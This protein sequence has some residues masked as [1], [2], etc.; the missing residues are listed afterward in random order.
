MKRISI[1]AGFT[2]V[3][4][5][6]V[7]TII[8]VLA[9]IILTSLNDARKEGID[10]KIMV[11]MGGIAKRAAIDNNEVFTYDVVCGT[12][13]Y[14][15]STE[16]VDLITSIHTLASSTVTCNSSPGAFAVSVPLNTAHWCIDNNGAAKEIPAALTAGDTDCD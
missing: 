11:E 13:G 16:I 5:L 2:I 1:Q 4:L 10:A 3:E 7:I 14:A 9:A 15:T 8:S 6:T 12:N